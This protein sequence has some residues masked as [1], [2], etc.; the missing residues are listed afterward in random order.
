MTVSVCYFFT[1]S[2]KSTKSSRADNALDN[3]SLDKRRKL[4]REKVSEEN[5]SGESKAECSCLV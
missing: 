4:K 3:K 5:K 2:N 1:L